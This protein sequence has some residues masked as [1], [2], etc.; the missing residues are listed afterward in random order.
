MIIA[1]EKQFRKRIV[2]NGA[3]KGLWVNYTKLYIGTL[4]LLI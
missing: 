3:E 4:F 1:T 2:R